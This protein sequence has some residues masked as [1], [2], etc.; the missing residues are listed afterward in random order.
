MPSADMSS[1]LISKPSGGYRFLPGIEPYCS[2]V[3]AEPGFEIVHVVL[4]KALPWFEGLHNAR[5]FLKFRD[6]PIDAL[7]GVELRCPKPHSMGGFVEFN[8][9]YRNLINDWGL[10]VDD[11]NPIARTNVAPVVAP[12]TET[13]LYGFSFCQPSEV[14][15]RTFVVAGGGELPHRDLDS[16][17]ILRRGETSPDAMRQKAECVVRIMQH[18]LRKLEADL[19]M[20][21]AIDVYTAHP[22]QELLEDI[23]LAGLPACAQRGVQ[24]FLTRPPI[25]EIEFEMDVRGVRQELI[26]DLSMS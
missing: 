10:P 24:W 16:V 6:L 2:G 14:R 23:I 19:D 26:L 4:Q 15:E 5:Q 7:C 8:R 20:L 1:P 9:D 11:M 25:E 18:R 22:L 13:V 12:P 21:S 17:H 3:I